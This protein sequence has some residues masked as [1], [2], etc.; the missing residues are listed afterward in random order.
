MLNRRINEL[1]TIQRVPLPPGVP[2]DDHNRVAGLLKLIREYL[3]NKDT[4]IESGTGMGVSTELFALTV[5]RVI[6]I[7]PSMDKK[8]RDAAMAV[9]MRYPT[10]VFF[11]IDKSE[12][13]CRSIPDESVDA[14]YLDGPHYYEFVRDD[15]KRWLP[16]IKKGGVICGHDYIDRPR[17]NFGVIRAVKEAFGE[18]DKVYEDTSWVK[19][20]V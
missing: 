1:M 16:K 7:D 17:F 11:H 8:W 6:T 2:D 10:K 18:P 4:V 12:N 9:A 14:A 3:T 13:V 5:G 15:I 20:V 19:R